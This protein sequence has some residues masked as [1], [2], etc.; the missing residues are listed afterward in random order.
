MVILLCVSGQA[1]KGIGL[2]FSADGALGAVP[3]IDSEV[4]PQR[5]DLAPH[6]FYKQFMAPARKIGSADGACK[7]RV[8]GKNR[9]RRVEAHPAGRVPGRVNDGDAVMSNL[10]DLS[11]FQEAIGLCAKSGSVQP[12]NQD[13]SLCDALQL[14]DTAHV[15]NVAV[16]DGDVLYGEAG[17]GYFFH[18]TKHFVSRVDHQTLVGLFASQDIAVGLIRTD[19][20]SSQHGKIL[21]NSH[22]Q[23]VAHFKGKIRENR[24]LS[25][26]G[27]WFQNGPGA[28]PLGKSQAFCYI[29]E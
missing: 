14:G 23:K 10:E 7:Q 18:N 22:S 17:T 19:N 5:K 20:E 29:H 26:A 13:R 24:L 9:S 4:I 27:R 28:N 8:S 25:S 11:F 2:A 15:V 16:G 21:L 1:E 3:R 12:V 6:S